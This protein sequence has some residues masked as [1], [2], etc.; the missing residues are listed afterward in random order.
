MRVHS[1]TEQLVL[2]DDLLLAGDNE[3]AL[4]RLPAGFFD[5]IYVDPPFN[6]GRAQARRTLSVAAASDGDR[7]G[8]GGR[9]YRSRLLRALSY[10][11]AF[12]DYLGFLEPRLARARE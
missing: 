12:A 6:T 2:D 9:R 3:P 7:T 11:D 1:V 4:A 10:D 5:L 8:F